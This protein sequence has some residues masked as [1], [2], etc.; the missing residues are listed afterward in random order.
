MIE[1]R[2]VNGSQVDDGT[3]EEG[4]TT[5]L[6][7]D[8]SVATLHSFMLESEAS[9]QFTETDHEAPFLI[10]HEIDVLGPLRDIS[11]KFG[12]FN[13]ESSEEDSTVT[14]N[15]LTLEFGALQQTSKCS[16]QGESSERESKCTTNYLALEFE[17]P[18][19]PSRARSKIPIIIDDT[20]LEEGFV[21]TD[22]NKED[23][24]VN[25]SEFFFRIDET[26]QSVDMHD[27]AHVAL[28]CKH[29]DPGSTR[30]VLS[31]KEAIDASNEED[32]VDAAQSKVDL[33][34]DLDANNEL[35]L[36]T[37][38]PMKDKG[39]SDDVT[40]HESDLTAHS[41][42]Q[43]DMLDERFY[44]MFDDEDSEI[45][46]QPSLDEI[47]ISSIRIDQDQ[48]KEV[49]Q[50]LVLSSP[51]R[52]VRD[53][54][55]KTSKSM[56]YD[57][58]QLPSS[59][60]LVYGH[61]TSSA[62]LTGVPLRVTSNQSRD[63]LQSDFQNNTNQSNANDK[64]IA[65]R[66][67]MIDNRL[68]SIDLNE[69]SLNLSFNHSRVS[70]STRHAPV[71]SLDLI[72]G[73]GASSAYFGG[74]ILG[75]GLEQRDTAT[76]SRGR[77]RS[78]TRKKPIE[79][80]ALRIEAFFYNRGMEIAMGVLYLALNYVMA[81]HGAYQFTE[82]GGFTTDNDLLRITLPIARA[83]GRLVTF[84]C[85]VLLLTSCKCLWTFTRTHVAPVIPIAFP[86][87]DVMPKYHRYV[88]LT[89]IFSGCIIHT[90]PQI[91][92]YSTRAIEAIGTDSES[93]FWTFGNGFAKKQLFISGMLLTIIFS[94]FFLT[95][96]KAFR[97]TAAGFRWFWF[98]HVGGIA[99]AYPLLLLHG[100]C[101]GN[102]V[103]FYFA[104]VPLILY[105]LD[106]SMRRSNISKTKIVRWKIHEDQGQQITELVIK[107]PLAFTYTPGQYVELRFRPISKR[108]WHPFTIA[109]APNER[110]HGNQ[111]MSFYI[112]NLGRWTGALFDC[113]SAFD[114]SKTKDLPEIDVRGPHG[115][116]AMN[117]FEYKHILVI[118][119]GVGV[120]PLLSIWKYLVA[121]GHAIVDLKRRKF[122]SLFTQPSARDGP[123][124]SFQS[125]DT[126]GISVQS[127][128]TFGLESND[129]D[130]EF[131]ETLDIASAKTHSTFRD[132][133]ILLQPI[134][135]SMTVCL[136]LFAL[137]VF[138][139]TITIVLRMYGYTVVAN[140]L[141]LLSSI[142]ALLVYGITITVSM[143]ARGCFKYSRSFKCWL[144]FSILF[145]DTTAIW[146][147]IQSRNN[148]VEE[149]NSE[150]TRIYLSIFG[151]VV[152]LHALRIFHIFYV[153]LKP[154]T[155]D[156][157]KNSNTLTTSSEVWSGKEEICS[158]QGILINRK[159]SSMRFAAKGLLPQI[160][161]DGLSDLF[162]IQFYGTREEDNGDDE[163][164]RMSEMM[165]SDEI[166]LDV[167]PS[168][169]DGVF[170]A[171]RPDWNNVFLQAINRAHRTN[172]EGDSVGVFFCGSPAIAKDLQVEAKR[173]TA[174][175]Q[176]VT[177]RRHGRACKC[178]LIVHTENF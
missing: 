143:I 29:D 96:L 70:N 61:G 69:E 93:M 144:E 100:T 52:D 114:L 150:N 22:S 158:V 64:P 24:E 107:R 165:G 172:K 101:R 44:M 84:N 161:Q 6:G 37:I 79:L 140:S 47:S 132:R 166:N 14:T 148:T 65:N 23:S 46:T 160:L 38:L 127:G 128:G 103:F 28:D 156:R 12:S 40:L 130:V 54:R 171:G 66:D 78:Q 173:I 55:F 5:L 125:E 18:Q 58:K 81:A 33:S 4:A 167:S 112:K 32:S 27:T 60:G 118:G 45:I 8:D 3:S 48:H 145:V 129:D 20:S 176:F 1:Q 110:S 135:D 157:M 109:S 9:Q 163:K 30:S 59:F 141:G 77:Q 108:E 62:Y 2:D 99:A 146:F 152:F 117:Y 35:S 51:S 155:K 85:A 56:L 123:R 153:T 76:S 7:D 106:I 11:S 53:F 134:L 105:L 80:K 121:R 151:Y 71:T 94:T 21:D 73:N 63:P 86:F 120:A 164:D 137:F 13:S 178:K 74:D 159:Y 111:E 104:M 119:S 49:K 39:S 50:S 43:N 138:G 169:L 124:E 16:S 147:S 115:A 10:N 17:E 25:A 177:Q 19:Q 122:R 98:F 139:E 175:H 68:S 15:Y 162:T 90:L 142:V 91:L 26:D 89:V 116:P 31:G 72:Y 136:S 36:A 174:Q 83:G 170:C 57:P 82:A 126:F 95:T 131:R 34:Q 87:D 97:Q 149:D 41:S 42:V 154:S 88:A 168:T 133:C 113:A 92:N 67:L 75:D 102:P